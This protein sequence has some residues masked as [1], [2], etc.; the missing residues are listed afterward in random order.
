MPDAHATIDNLYMPLVPLFVTREYI[1]TYISRPRRSNS[2]TPPVPAT[3][4]PHN[5]KTPQNCVIKRRGQ[6]GRLSRSQHQAPVAPNSSLLVTPHNTSVPATYRIRPD[7]PP[8]E[9]IT[10]GFPF[11][12]FLCHPGSGVVSCGGL[13]SNEAHVMHYGELP[14]NYC[15]SDGKLYHTR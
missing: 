14:V 11:A 6:T 4:Y 12:V 9:T 1:Y 7:K 3:P 13:L 15:C 8:A 5:I 2:A 10:Q